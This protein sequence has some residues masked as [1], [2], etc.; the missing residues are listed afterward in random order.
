MTV[1][2]KLKLAILA[3]L[4]SPLSSAITL[5]PVQI[6][7]SAGE[8]LYAEVNFRNATPNQ[9]IRVSLASPEDIL[10]I[11]ANHQP[12]GHLNF[13]TRRNSNGEGVITITSS[14]PIT[15]SELNFIIKIEAGG[16]ARLQHIRKSLNG[17]VLTS[18]QN[19][20]AHGEKPLAPI[21]IVS[22]KEIA[23]NLPVS[24]QHK[25]AE[26]SV[27]TEK[28]LNV[29]H[30]L[31]PALEKD[32]DSTEIASVAPAIIQNPVV[33]TIQQPAYLSAKIEDEVTLAPEISKSEEQEISVLSSTSNLSVS[34]SQ[35]PLVKEYQSQL[36]AQTDR[37]LEQQE[38]KPA[39]KTEIK[40]SQSSINSAVKLSTQSQQH[41]VKSNDSLW[42]IANQMAKQEKRTLND[43]MRE[44]KANNEHAFIQGDANRLRRGA[45]LNLNV[46][47]TAPTPAKPKPQVVEPGLNKANT[48]SAKAK[49]RLD[50]AEMSLVAENQQDSKAASAT[51]TSKNAKTS[52]DLALK[53]MTARE[54]TVKLQRNVTQLELALNQKDHRLQLL[55]ARLAE[56]QHQLK[57]QQIDKKPKS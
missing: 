52:K 36:N 48:Q 28:I 33:N 40:T 29:R 51:N 27:P 31:P 8:L 21:M 20:L 26:T 32:I 13:Y 45:V 22:E 42:K 7:S 35:D 11:G 12:P 1:N 6:Q 25:K 14:R 16:S 44:I 18:Q 3:V 19:K 53:V 41:I 24:T 10:N 56:L 55:N 5:D 54:K 46:Q 47:S 57:A 30:S 9:N 15:E 23:L 34:Q 17:S 37:N 38:I 2:K 4:A 39:L 43:V 50:Q 49:Y